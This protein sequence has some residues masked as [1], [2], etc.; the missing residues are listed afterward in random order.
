MNYLDQLQFTIGFYDTGA[1][2]RVLCDTMNIK[3]RAVNKIVHR[4]TNEIG[5]LVYYTGPIFKFRHQA[6]L[7]LNYTETTKVIFL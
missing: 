5:C 3:R 2:Q 1:F 6:G 4:V 7:M